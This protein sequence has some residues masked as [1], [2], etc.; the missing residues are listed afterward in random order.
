MEQA[1]LDLTASFG[2]G[3]IV[4]LMIIEVVFPLVPS[5]IVLPLAG[6]AAANGKLWLPLVILIASIGATLGSTV[7]Y[8]IAHLVPDPV[9][10]R[11]VERYGKWFGIGKKDV[12]RADAWFDR[13]A[14]MAVFIC[15]MIP[16]LRTVISLPAGLSKMHPV[17]FMVATFLGTLVWTTL[18]VVAGYMLG[19]QYQKIAHAVGLLS[20]AV[21]AVITV[22]VIYFIWHRRHVIKKALGR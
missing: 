5:E 9:I 18:L 14:I 10:Y 20:Y 16:G 6:F 12:E 8:A 22:A 3:G 13:N 15:R 17:P 2:Y 4:I 19:D 1:I 7:I 11:L 21:V